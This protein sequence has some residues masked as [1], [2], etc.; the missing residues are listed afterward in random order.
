MGRRQPPTKGTTVDT[1][2]LSVA[3]QY[4]QAASLQISNA[5]TTLAT[6]GYMQEAE[7]VARTASILDMDVKLLM[8]KRSE[9]RAAANLS[10]V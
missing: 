9:L 1:Y 3:M 5:I 8:L 7:E 2:E 6:T 10:A 4:L